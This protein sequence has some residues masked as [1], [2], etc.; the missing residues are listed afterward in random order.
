MSFFGK[1]KDV[2]YVNSPEHFLQ[3]VTKYLLRV[4]LKSVHSTKMCLTVSGHCQV[5]FPSVL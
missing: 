5:G 3:E 1:I 4:S 2:T